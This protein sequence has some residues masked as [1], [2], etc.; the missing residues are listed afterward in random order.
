VQEA[1][2]GDLVEHYDL[3]AAGDTCD[4]VGIPDGFAA[5]VARL[6]AS[7]PPPADLAKATEVFARLGGEKVVLLPDRNSPPTRSAAVTVP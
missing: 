7:A 5:W 4:L 1:E 3:F 6:P 2:L